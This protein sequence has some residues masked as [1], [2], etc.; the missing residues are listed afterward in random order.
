MIHVQ[1][2]LFQQILGASPA[3]RVSNRY[4]VAEESQNN[5][6]NGQKEEASKKTDNES[7]RLGLGDN[8]F[9]PNGNDQ[10][11]DGRDEKLVKET[12]KQSK[13]QRRKFEAGKGLF[14]KSVVFFFGI[15]GGDQSFVN[16]RGG[17]NGRREGR[18][19]EH[20]VARRHYS[21]QNVCMVGLWWCNSSVWQKEEEVPNEEKEILKAAWR[22]FAYLSWSA[23]K[24]RG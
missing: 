6:Y 13:E 5:K 3:S 19:S 4:Q 8:I 18:I 12:D 23:S 17:V 20:F 10:K 21:E 15:T 2:D 22:Q 9:A 24:Q 11:L 7:I 16:I 1:D 14:F